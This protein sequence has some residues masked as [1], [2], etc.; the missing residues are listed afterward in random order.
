MNKD[1]IAVNLICCIFYL[2]IALTLLWFKQRDWGIL[3]L[4]GAVAHFS[5]A[6]YLWLSGVVIT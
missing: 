2:M 5:R 1:M 4:G 6:L 3:Y